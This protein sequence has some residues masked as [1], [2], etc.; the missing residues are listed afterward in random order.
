MK[1]KILHR[2]FY[3]MPLMLLFFSC[4][5]NK[6]TNEQMSWSSDGAKLAV[7]TTESNE[8]LIVGV[9]GNKVE[10]TTVADTT[11]QYKLLAPQWSPKNDNLRYFKKGKN[12]TEVWT[13]S[14]ISKS[15]H[16]ITQ[17]ADKGNETSLR[18]AAWLPND[19]RLI[20]ARHV[21]SAGT[22]Q[23]FSSTA[24]GQ[25]KQSIFKAKG[26]LLWY[27]ISSDGNWLAA[28]VKDNSD[29]SSADIWKMKTDGSSKEKIY[30]GEPVSVL[31]WAPD[32]SK[33]AFIRQIR[34][35]KD[36][37][38]VIRLIDSDGKN[39]Q[40]VQK[41]K[42]QITRIDWSP[43]GD[44]ISLIQREKSN[45][46]LWVLDMSTRFSTKIT[47]D[48]LIDFFGWD[49]SGKLYF[50]IAY[51]ESPAISSGTEQEYRELIESMRGIIRENQ[52]MCWQPGGLSRIDKNIFGF[53]NSETTQRSAFFIAYEIQFLSTEK[54]VPVIRW[55]NGNFEAIPRTRSENLGSADLYFQHQKYEKALAQLSDYWHS[56]FNSQNFRTTFDVMNIL[57]TMR[58][59]ED[60][61]QMNKLFTGLNNGSLLRTILILRKL[62]EV[63]KS[64]W[65]LDQSLALLNQSTKNSAFESERD[66]A[67]IWALVSTYLKYQSAGDGIRDL[68]YFITNLDNDS[69][70]IF[71]LLF[72]Q[73]ILA[74]ENDQ[75]NLCINKLEHSLNYYTGDADGTDILSFVEILISGASKKA[76]EKY[77]PV[78]QKFVTRLS[79]EEEIQHAYK[80]IGHIYEMEGDAAKSYLAYQKAV[81]YHFDSHKIWEKLFEIESQ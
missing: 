67:F 36:S 16:K 52:L 15:K 24:D 1:T 12:E 71:S 59:P 76:R 64:N 45:S 34:E 50:T 43:K 77:I 10:S 26:I 31:S 2:F 80:L 6:P 79:D 18:H 57:Q 78:L 61:V 72:A 42:S 47:F 3:I 74:F 28:S 70:S 54:Y 25:Q 17:I 30:E 60:S 20:Y 73:S 65:L 4:K 56:D 8:L 11:T 46:N 33:L 38:D 55:N 21:R 22:S 32:G 53:E 13:Y 40:I 44:F 58:T 75:E 9:T 49:P 23:L 81:S 35:P 29:P 7:A 27:D 39:Q 37:S 63:E 48:N 51:P 41:F 5:E 19:N 69:L 14:L 62:N 66:E 68:D